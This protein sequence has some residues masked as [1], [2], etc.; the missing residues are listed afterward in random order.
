MIIK[1]TATE[2]KELSFE[3][4]QFKVRHIERIP[5][6]LLKA[7]H[8]LRKEKNSVK[9]FDNELWL[10]GRIPMITYMQWCKDHPELKSSDP[11]ISWP[12]LKKLMNK[13]END[14]F[15]TYAGNL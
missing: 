11:N 6:G 4:D 13:P 1:S 12:M 10:V 9:S 5:D 14:I 2:H 7:N 3:G 15:K 8:E